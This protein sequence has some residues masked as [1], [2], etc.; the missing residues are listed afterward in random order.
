MLQPSWSR[1]VLAP[2]V[3]L[4]AVLAA[5]RGIASA[6]SV[7][8]AG[9]PLASAA[10]ARGRQGGLRLALE[11]EYLR[12]A[13]GSAD[14]PGTEEVL[15]QLTARLLGVYSPLPRIN[16][17]VTVPYVSKTMTMHGAGHHMPMSATRGLGDVELAIRWFFLE[18][19]NYDAMRRQAL[20][21]SAGSS[22][23][24]GA[25][26][27]RDE[28]VRLD[29]HAQIGTGA[30]GPFA[31][32]LYRLQRDPWAALAS[33]SYRY[34]TR[35]PHGF[36]F[37]E[38]LLWSTQAQYMPGERLALA[39]GLDGRWVAADDAMG[40]KAPNT[41]GLA[42]AVA[43]ALH[44][45]VFRGAWLVARAQLPVFTALHG[46]Q[47]VGPVVIFGLQFSVF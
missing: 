2:A 12:V 27:A 14:T 19:T 1:R 40:G 15:D 44:L 7:C 10:D 32:L 30:F 41:G 9:D 47:R 23:P 38:A 46:Q 33:V 4:V 29:D 3:V 8:N 6:C 34:R 21:L 43:P 13:S 24:T 5:P 45:E 11:G 18:S 16:T 20:A 26:G 36:R 31:G 42:I 22:I 37:G 17:I 25:H 35:N 28:G 39:V